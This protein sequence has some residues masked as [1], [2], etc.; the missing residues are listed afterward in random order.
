MDS[1]T[2]SSSLSKCAAVGIATALSL[3]VAYR[4]WH[5]KQGARLTPVQLMVERNSRMH[6][7]ESVAAGRAFKPRPR[8]TWVTQIAHSLRS[9]GH[10]DF[11]EITEVVPWDICAKDCGQNV[12]DEQVAHPRLYK[13]HE[14]YDTVPKG[15]KYIYVARNPLDAFVSFFHF[16]PAYMGIPAGAMPMSDFANAMFGGLSISGGIW[17]HFLGWWHHRK[18]PNVLWLFFEDLKEDHVGCV[19][20]IAEFMGVDTKDEELIQ[21]A[22]KQSTF[23]FMSTHA[24]QFDDHFLR[25]KIK[26]QSGLDE[27]SKFTVGKVRKDCGKPREPQSL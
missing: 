16:L 20:R 13:S 9:R 27:D 12:D 22:V 25:D 14:S 24:T 8:T 11:G 1:S 5:K 15:A 19:R 4:F 3:G 10:M 26:V 7:P 6:S 23:D 21:L 17:G 18:D 2:S